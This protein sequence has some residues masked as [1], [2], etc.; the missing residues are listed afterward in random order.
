MENHYLV[1]GQLKKI[2]DLDK[3]YSL[4]CDYGYVI[5]AIDNF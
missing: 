3:F 5:L 1:S 2:H 4:A